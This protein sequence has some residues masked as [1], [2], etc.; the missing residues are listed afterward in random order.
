ML[1]KYAAKRRSALLIRSPSS[2]LGAKEAVKT[3]RAGKAAT[4][5]ANL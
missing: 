5:S 1:R 3:N 4:L 2:L